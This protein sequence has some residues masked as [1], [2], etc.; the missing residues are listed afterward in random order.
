MKIERIEPGPEDQLWAYA[1]HLR[2]QINRAY[3][4]PAHLLREAPQD[5]AFYR[6][7]AEMQREL[8]HFVAT[9]VL[10]LGAPCG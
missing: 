5:A 6:R 8:D 4:V 7:V 10:P 9:H 3:R 1:C 2:D